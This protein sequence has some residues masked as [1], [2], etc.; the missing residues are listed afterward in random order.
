M[1]YKKAGILVFFFIIL[2][3]N[4]AYANTVNI[5]PTSLRY[6][7]VL[8]GGYSSLDLYISTDSKSD[9]KVNFAVA[10]GIANW[11]SVENKGSLFLNSNSPVVIS[12]SIIPPEGV[13]NG[14]HQGSIILSFDD[15]AQS[16]ISTQGS[17]DV[18][19][20][21]GVYVTDTKIQ[22]AKV[23]NVILED[24]TILEPLV[25]LADITNNGNTL[26]KPKLN[27][28]IKNAQGVL[29]KSASLEASDFIY[30]T[31]QQKLTF[32]LGILDQGE[33]KA[34]INFYLDD[35]TLLK[36]VEIAFNVVLDRTQI[37]KIEFTQL[38][39][40]DRG[41][42]DN[43]FNLVA[44]VRNNGDDTTVRFSGQLYEDGNFLSDITS[45]FILVQRGQENQ[46]KFGFTPSKLGFYKIVGRLETPNLVRTQDR[47]SAFEIVSKDTTLEQVPLSSN[48]TLAIGL[49]LLAIF[50]FV[51][52]N[53]M[54]SRQI[55]KTKKMKKRR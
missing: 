20:P 55:K 21:L 26:V 25:L 16:G 11:V 39:S 52:I 29:V 17:K 14:E 38:Q 27:V 33:Y 22:E 4:F 30:P 42:L 10:G 1:S 43:D 36:S 23:N 54:R 2:A 35:G 53:K 48:P 40:R 50:I 8:R 3:V 9:I 6:E 41:H 5:N 13:S 46:I 15:T 28:E 49:M 18:V 47:E 32:N 34:K 7:N 51:R 37:R 12:V 45:D 24:T 31:K 44:Q 19:I